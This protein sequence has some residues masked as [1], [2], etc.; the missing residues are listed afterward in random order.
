MS[1]RLTDWQE[2]KLQID[3]N[4]KSKIVCILPNRFSDH[5]NIT[6]K[7]FSKRSELVFLLFRVPSLNCG[8]FKWLNCLSF[9]FFFTILRID[10]RLIL[11]YSVIFL[12]AKCVWSRFFCKQTNSSIKSTFSSV[13]TVLGCPA[14]C[15]LHV[16]PV[17]VNVFNNRF[18]EE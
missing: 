6:F 11:V 4:C 3:R 10:V 13:E 17:F 2:L 5:L 7:S 18:T 8:V 9:L 12:S 16:E 15:L 1:A 14:S